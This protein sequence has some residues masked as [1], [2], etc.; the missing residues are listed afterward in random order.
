MQAVKK[1]AKIT[2]IAWI[3]AVVALSLFLPSSGDYKVNSDEGSVHKDKPSEVAQQLN[4]QE[5][6]TKDGLTALLVFHQDGKISEKNRNKIA[7]FSKW[8]ASGSKP[9]YVESALPFHKFPEQIQDKM[10]SKDQSTLLFNVTLQKGADSDQ[11]HDTLQKLTDKTETL[12]AN[13][14]EMKI[15]GPAGIS[16]DTISMF[17]NA[18]FILMAATVVLIFILLILIYRS[19]ILA[20]TPLIIAGIVYA[21]VDRLIGLG[22]KLDWFT[23]DSSAVSIMMVLLFAVIT[24]YSLFIFSRYREELRLHASKYTSMQTGMHHVSEVIFF[25]GGTI[26]LAM[27]ALFATI[28]KPYN[29]FAPVFSIAVVVIAIAGLTLIPSIFALMGRKAFWPFIPKV[30]PKNKPQHK[31]WGSIGHFVK[32]HPAVL[33]LVMV[34]V[35]GFGVANLFTMNYSFN[36][37]KSFPEDTPSREGFELLED[38]YPAGKLAPVTVQLQSNQAI[39]GDTDFFEKI[40]KLE[41]Q[42][43]IDK[44][45]SEVS[46]EITQSMID[47]K[48]KLPADFMSDSKHA[49]KFQ[50]TL[51][52]NPYEQKALDTLQQ[53]RDKAQS[54][55]SESDLQ[56]ETYSLHFSGQT[57]EQLDVHDM[58]KRDTIILFSLVIVLITIVLAFQTRSFLL[59]ILMVSTI[60]LSFAATI[61]FCWFIFE[62]LLGYDAI[63]YRLPVYTFVFMVALGVDYNIMLV[64]R[65]K[66]Y[67]KRMPWKEAVASGVTHT[68]GVI[69]SAGIILAATFTVLMTQPLQELFLFGFTMGIGILFDT[70]L[71]RGVF[72]PS[73]LIL[74]HKKRPDEW[75]SQDV[76]E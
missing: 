35:L 59:P 37:L 27:L 70:F 33:A 67:A 44:N 24:D 46:P 13:G 39:H 15:T 3:V 69:S 16:S 20:I 19:P 34:V 8:L 66:E 75:H 2:L 43:S 58:N 53:F 22:G 41:K 21:V 9:T 64:S 65:I 23:V 28:F 47:G 7:D 62:H 68:G 5:F 17:K 40:Q 18:D 49:V 31:F 29:H 38:N 48:D 61:G 32:K 30:N 72:L 52:S 71:I 36:M 74:T 12:H 14:M 45:V 6:P 55:L 57:A 1:G 11:I 76:N 4:D 42:F 54:Y 10:F 26:V 25:S 50:I 60:L 73:I 56:A 51:N 63:S